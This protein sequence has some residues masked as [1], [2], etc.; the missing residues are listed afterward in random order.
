MNCIC[1]EKRKR[2][3][4]QDPDGTCPG[5]Q[6]KKE[7]TV[8]EPKKRGFFDKFNPWLVRASLFLAGAHLGIPGLSA[9][10]GSALRNTS[11]FASETMHIVL[12]PGE[13]P[14]QA[15]DRIHSELSVQGIEPANYQ[16]IDGQLSFDV[17]ADSIT[18]ASAVLGLEEPAADAVASIGGDTGILSDLFG[19]LW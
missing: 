3:D 14:Q 5:K 6:P 1:G 7:K 19:G 11:E 16:F 9:I 18:N 13:S 2:C 12:N 4:F 10:A 8:I 17:P 15:I